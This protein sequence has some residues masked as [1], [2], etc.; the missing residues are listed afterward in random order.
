[1]LEGGH[2]NKSFKCCFQDLHTDD[3]EVMLIISSLSQKTGATS[4]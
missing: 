2:Q 1:M 3:I 4:N